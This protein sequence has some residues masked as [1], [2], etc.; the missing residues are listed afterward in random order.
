M[1][2][3]AS[4][5]LALLVVAALLVKG[6][7][8][9]LWVFLATTPL[10]AAAAV[11]LPAAGGASILVADVTAL[12]MC[13]LVLLHPGG[14]RMMAGT[15]RHGQ[16]GYWMLLLLLW[17]VAATLLFP[18]V[19][20]G[21]TE[22]FAI[23]RRANET[24]IVTVPLRPGT[25]NLT[26]L[27]RMILGAA[28]FLA[29]ATVFRLR[30]EAA[31]VQRAIAAA[32]GI[33][34][35]LGWLDVGAA[36]A[37]LSGLLEPLRSANYAILSEVR[38]AGLKRMIGG[39]PEASAFG[40]Y[41]IGLF[42]FWLQFWIGTPGSRMARWMLVLSGIAVLRSTSSAAYVALA[43]F[44]VT[45]GLVTLVLRLRARV[46][47][48]GAAIAV[49]ALLT[50]WLALLGLFA[51]YELVQP[52][53]AFLDRALFNKLAGASGVERMSWNAQAWHNFVDTLG[54]GAGLGSVRA[55]S[56]GVAVLAS[57]GVVGAVLYLRLLAGV[58]T[59]PVEQGGDP[60]RAVVVR[61]LRAA[62]LALLLSAMLTQATPDLG[63]AF[64]A[65]AGLA[66]GLTRGGVTHGA[67]GRATPV[68]P[69]TQIGPSP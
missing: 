27:F 53:Q 13:G 43:A 8:R 50:G 68:I 66:A 33:N 44:L 14:V 20:R 64:F 51:A 10:G 57:L 23:A 6:P 28:T 35:A 4:S 67:P 47:R 7:F 26:Q 29:L 58:L 69:A 24:G 5:F 2:I 36:A 54:L 34:V 25:G 21:Q 16:P 45:F 63:L 40:Y 60:Q 59:G 17:S 39:F 62:C 38:M 12:A 1:E 32:T 56:W 31:T 19:F 37:G 41:A 65:F 48:R 42:A 15:M 9:G 22:V 52:V 3:V 11:N 61:S 18:T 46:A 49:A 30:P 55:S